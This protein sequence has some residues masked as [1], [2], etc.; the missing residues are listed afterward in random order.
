MI[1]TIDFDIVELHSMKKYPKL[2]YYIGDTSLLSRPKISVVGT[3]HPTQY[4]KQLTH[5]ICLKLSQN[6]MCIV[7]GG[8][9]GV[10]AIAHNAA[11]ASNTI[12]VAGTGLDKRYPAVNK[13]LIESIEKQGL[14]LSQFEEK[15]SSNAWHFPL[16]NELVVAL[17]DTLIVMQADRDSGTMRS[18]EYAKKMGKKIYVLSHRAGESAGS[19]D[20]IYTNDATPIVDVD[21]F[22]EQFSTAD[23]SKEEDSFLLYCQSNP[24][25]DEA[26]QRYATEVFE[27]ELLG[28]I[29]IRNGQIFI[30]V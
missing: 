16:R 2:L 17:S 4:T 8:A 28:K 30:G 9:M 1:Q 18:V 26:V 27:Y 24:S 10:D 13:K 15:K 12:M 22:V 23:V 11:G 29:T 3:R 14:V 25:Y 6:G 5:E 20:L 21:S 7:S 19:N